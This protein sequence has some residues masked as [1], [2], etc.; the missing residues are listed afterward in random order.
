RTPQ[1]DPALPPDLLRPQDVQELRVRGR[2]LARLPRPQARAA[3]EKA[4]RA[5]PP[6]SP[7]GRRGKTAPHHPAERLRGRREGGLRLHR[8]LLPGL[9]RALPADAAPV[10]PHA[11]LSEGTNG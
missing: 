3:V 10:S 6:R 11:R 5:G 4:P 7:H 9:P 1:G 2:L 8:R